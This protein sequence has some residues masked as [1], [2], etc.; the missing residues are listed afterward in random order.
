VHS[1]PAPCYLIGSRKF[2]RIRLKKMKKKCEQ[3]PSPPGIQI[4]K[5]W[6]ELARVIGAPRGLGRK[7]MI[8]MMAPSSFISR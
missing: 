4:G 6:R 8:Q 2:I 3:D 7:A 1:V 5:I